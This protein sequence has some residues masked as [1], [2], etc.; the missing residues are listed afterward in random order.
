MLLIV[1]NPGRCRA[2]RQHTGRAARPRLAAAEGH[3]VFR[4]TEQLWGH[5]WKERSIERFTSEEWRLET[6]CPTKVVSTEDVRI[7]QYRYHEFQ[8]VVEWRPGVVRA[9]TL[10]PGRGPRAVLHAVA[11]RQEDQL[12]SGLRGRGV[13]G[14]PDHAEYSGHD[15]PGASRLAAGHGVRHQYL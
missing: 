4:E 6:Q 9:A 13:R 10:V 5:M 11:A 15:P 8:L 14:H 1:S 3:G 7:Q 12:L 2:G